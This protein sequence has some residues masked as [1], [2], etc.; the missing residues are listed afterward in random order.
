MCPNRAPEEFKEFTSYL[1]D[2]WLYDYKCRLGELG[3]ESEGQYEFDSIGRLEYLNDS[4]V[5][6]PDVRA[7]WRGV[8]R[9]DHRVIAVHGFSVR[10]ALDRELRLMRYY[11][12]SLARE[13]GETRYECRFDQGHYIAHRMGGPIIHNLF[14]QRADINRGHGELGKVYRAMETYAVRNP[15]TFVF[16][17]PIYGDGT[18]HPFFLEYGILRRD[19]FWVEIFPNRYSYT[20]YTGRSCMPSWRLELDE[21][22]S[23]KRRGHEKMV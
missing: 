7:K 2:A 3:Y 23:W 12:S 11:E 6:L 5:C 1:E 21:Q 22:P 13:F 17:R 9:E 20:P 8:N 15:G 18:S 10:T 14:P 4:A 19:L 16:S